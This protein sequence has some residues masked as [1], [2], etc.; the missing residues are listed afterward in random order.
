[1]AGWKGWPE[2]H[3]CPAGF[4]LMARLEVELGGRV[5]ALRPGR[6]WLQRD[7]AR[8]ARL[9]VRTIGRIERGGGLG[10]WTIRSGIALAVRRG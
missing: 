6:G 7:L 8:A 5:R 3:K 9:P 2:G 4:L 10:H 1:M